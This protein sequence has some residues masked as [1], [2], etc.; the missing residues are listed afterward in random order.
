MSNYT[1]ILVGIIVA[2]AT[3]CL[4]ALAIL[5][6]YDNYRYRYRVTRGVTYRNLLNSQNR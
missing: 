6:W 4:S 5:V 1:L 3:V 2:I